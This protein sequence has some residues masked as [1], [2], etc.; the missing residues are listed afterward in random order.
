MSKY[1]LTGEEA[2]A[3]AAVKGGAD[4]FSK[5]LAR[6]LRDIHRRHPELVTICDPMGDYDP[7]GQLPCF[8]AIATPKG[9]AFLSRRQRS[10]GRAVSEAAA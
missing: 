6:R 2:S 9:V 5:L 10:V 1:Q 3:L 8:G 4:V 7:V